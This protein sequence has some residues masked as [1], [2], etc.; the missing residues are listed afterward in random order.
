M[1]K[2]GREDGLEMDLWELCSEL[3]DRDLNEMF[4]GLQTSPEQL[5]LVVMERLLLMHP[6]ITRV[7]V[8]DGRVT[9]VARNTPR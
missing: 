7:E 9:G 6:K 3:A 2:L 1:E 4:P 5:S 8:G